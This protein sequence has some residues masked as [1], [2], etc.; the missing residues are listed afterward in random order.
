MGRASMQ[1][2]VVAGMAGIA[3]FGVLDGRPSGLGRGAGGA[4]A[5]NSA[6]PCT[7]RPSTIVSTDSMPRISS[8]GTE[9]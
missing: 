1:A 7:M 6:A 2:G 8:T 3:R 5:A 4:S 9:K